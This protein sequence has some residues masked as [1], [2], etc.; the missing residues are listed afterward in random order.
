MAAKVS[1]AV[2]VMAINP[3]FADRIL[4]GTKK[5]EFRRTIPRREVTHVMIYS[6]APCKVIVG[7]FEVTG[8]DIGAPADIWKRFGQNS[9][10]SAEGFRSYY[11]G[12]AK[13][14]AIK[15]GRVVAFKSP[16]PLIELSPNLSPP[17]S[18][19]YLS[20]EPVKKLRLKLSPRRAAG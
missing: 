19:C 15:V 11:R 2:A 5:V 8:I 13:A 14:V 18:F 7:Y 16:L 4:A 17:Q 1:P 12:S 20:G 9:G 6:T 3:E 10:I